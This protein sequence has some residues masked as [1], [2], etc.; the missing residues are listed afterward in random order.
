[1]FNPVEIQKIF[2]NHNNIITINLQYG[3][4]TENAPD[5]FLPLAA[6]APSCSYPTDCLILVYLLTLIFGIRPSAAALGT[7]ASA[8]TVHRTVF[9]RLLRKLPP[10]RIP[11][12]ETYCQ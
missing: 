6:Q 10:V 3:I 9:F 2:S 8:K 7:P 4:K 12:L 11:P 1:M 5:R